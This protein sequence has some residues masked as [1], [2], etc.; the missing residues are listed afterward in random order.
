MCS[1]LL[2]CKEGAWSNMSSDYLE[3]KRADP[4]YPACVA[5]LP[6]AP[7]LLYV[8][9][10]ARVLEQPSIS[11]IGARSSTPY[12]RALAEMAA[13]IAVDANLTV[14]SGGAKGCDQ[15]AGHAA[16]NAGGCHVVVLG[17][18]ADVPYPLSSRDLI[19]RTLAT[20]GAVVSLEPWGTPPMRWAFPKR[21]RVIAALSSAL[22]VSEAGMPSGT[23]STAETAAQLGREILVAPGSVFSPQSRGANYLISNGA[24]C[25]ADEEA[26][27]VAIS[28]IYG[29]LRYE[30]PA[31]RGVTGI[32]GREKRVLTMLVANPMSID[33][34]SRA[35][36]MGELDCLQMLS[37]MEAAGVVERMIDGRF[38]PTK[39]A[40]HACTRMGQNG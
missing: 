1:R 29:V 31:A 39:K 20:G 40:L 8:R 3:I 18:G 38:S 13:R 9:G 19:D 4:S 22:F 33:E 11:I 30:R 2:S 6:D 34:L 7:E 35:L 37:G 16:L 23:F 25:I 27:E 17:T 14:V 12:G 15:A 26:L 5:E 28:R 32:S 36:S 10:D 24:C 21:N